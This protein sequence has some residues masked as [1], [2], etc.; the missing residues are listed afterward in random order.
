MNS[1]FNVFD[2]NNDDVLDISSLNSSGTPCII[3]EGSTT[4]LGQ[5]TM[6]NSG[7]AK[8]FGYVP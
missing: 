3:I 8:M 6:A 7:A 5:I 4:N 1:K 2:A